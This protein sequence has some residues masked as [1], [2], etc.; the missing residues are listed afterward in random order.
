M[1][2]ILAYFQLFIRGILKD[3]YTTFLFC[4]Y[5][6]IWQRFIHIVVATPGVPV[7]P[8]GQHVAGQVGH[9]DL[10]VTRPVRTPDHTVAATVLVG[11]NGINVTPRVTSGVTEVTRML[12]PLDD[13]GGHLTYTVGHGHPTCR[14][15]LHKIILTQTLNNF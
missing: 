10:L 6:L 5:H 13:G 7:V 14:T 2:A 3:L 11:G 9:A 12:N 15:N 1:T 8:L 4:T